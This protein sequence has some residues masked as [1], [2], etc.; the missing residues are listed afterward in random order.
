[1]FALASLAAA[2]PER[3]VL[4]NGD[5]YEG[6]VVDGVWTGRGA[7]TGKQ[8]RYV[9]EFRNG[10]MHGAGVFHW[11]DG[12]VYEGAFVNERRHGRGKLTWPDGRVFEGNFVN[13]QRQ[14]RGVLAWPNGNVYAG[15]FHADQ[16]TGGGR[17]TWQNQD[18]YEGDFVNGERSGWGTHTW[19]NGN[20]YVGEW[21]GNRREGI[22]AYHWKDGTV[23]HGQ[24]VANRMHGFG[25]K[26][27]PDDG[28]RRFQ[29]WRTGQL[30]ADRAIA[31][32]ARCG[33][34]LDGH[35]WMFQ[36]AECVNGRA[37]GRGV[38]VRLDGEAF[39]AAGR[40]VL[41]ELVQGEVSWLTV[42]SP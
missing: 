33:L 39:I 3:V 19:R 28:E 21:R 2:A 15:D 8:H 12:R 23:Y 9:G 27:P 20:R 24:F 29:R 37:H 32:D 14:G 41:G 7:Y 26:H 40:F 35:G 30:V 42:L 10:K 31:A 11:P 25:V 38:A 34:D 5:V 4:P 36:S 22:G 18:V 1:M 16:I 17:L 6:D 13:G